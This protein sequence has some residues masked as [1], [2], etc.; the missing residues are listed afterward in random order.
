LAFPLEQC[1]L[2]RSDFLYKDNNVTLY[3]MRRAAMLARVKASPLHAAID[4]RRRRD[5]L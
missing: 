1:P 5:D 4:G 2:F 3:G